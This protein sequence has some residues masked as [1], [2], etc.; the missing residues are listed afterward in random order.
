MGR[1]VLWARRRG[2]R[3]PVA[4]LGLVVAVGA[5]GWLPATALADF[6]ASLALDQSA[7]TTAGSSPAI[8]FD[9]TFAS[10]TGDSVK[11]TAITLPPGL[12][13]NESIAGGAC[14]RS[15]TPNVACQVGSGTLGLAGGGS[16]SLTVDLVKPPNP[17]D[18]GGLTFVSGTTPLATSDVTLGA[19]SGA[20]IVSN[21]AAGIAET[22]FSFTDLRLPSS[23]PSPA[24]TV[25]M[26][27]VSQAGVSVTATA[28]LI[29]TGCSGLRYAPTLAVSEATDSRDHGTTLGLEITQAANEA[30]SKTIA[31]KLPSGLSVDLPADGRC[32]T[33]V[34]TGCVIGA[35][36]ATS[37]LAPTK[38]NG[39]VRLAG[40]PTSPTVTVLFP[41]PF[42]ITLVGDVS[43]SAGTVTIN[44]VPDV[45]L[46]DLNLMITGPSGHAAFITSC[47]P[48]NST[49]TFTSQSG[50]TKTVS[51]QVRLAHC[52]ASPTASGSAGGLASGHP[53]LRITASHG[54]GAAGIASIA[55]GL[56]A[57]LKFAR[58]A[59]A[60]SKA[61]VT[62]HG[63]RCTKG[64]GVLSARAKSV[65]LEGGKLVITL[66]KPVA[67]VTVTMSGPVLTETGSLQSDVK[68]HKVQSVTA[69]LKVADAKHTSTLVPL[70]LTAR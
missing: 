69:T 52:A 15:S 22:N 23:C 54:Q 49:G 8:G 25:T 1:F 38:L 16:Q 26:T 34:G 47:I 3:R 63:T 6:T 42:A 24:A 66:K 27:A 14:L 31:I 33:G 65:A 12:L 57:G 30:A 17:A 13:T 61:C 55:I 44:N 46:T 5:L 20:T 21:L 59:I 40:S 41:A 56:P 32:L 11:S 29:V 28:P 10:T 18:I 67:S 60:S 50:V 39:T 2:S 68:N 7:G 9:A 37:P 35:A 48:S 43:V 64:L 36:T 51:A 70:K 45:P 4:L 53:R 62:R 19:T 58:S